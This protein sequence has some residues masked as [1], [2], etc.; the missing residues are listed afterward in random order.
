MGLEYSAQ[1][2]TEYPGM[3]QAQA[4]I[5]RHF[6]TLNEPELRLVTRAVDAFEHEYGFKPHSSQLHSLLMDSA[7]WYG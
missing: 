1:F 2:Q 5:Y 6:K 3:Q 7:L 4:Q